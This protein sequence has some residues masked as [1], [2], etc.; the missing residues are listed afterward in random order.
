MVFYLPLF[1]CHKGSDRLKR[2]PLHTLQVQFRV[3]LFCDPFCLSLQVLT[4]LLC[5]TIHFLF[6]IPTI[7]HIQSASYKGAEISVA[8]A[9]VFKLEL[10]QMVGYTVQSPSLL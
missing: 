9:M 10:A 6:Y 7:T 3:L 4:P 1:Q 5:I 8:C 2:L